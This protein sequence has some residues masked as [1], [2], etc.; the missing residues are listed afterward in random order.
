MKHFYLL[1][2]FS[3]VFLN[4]N[5]QFDFYEDFE[6]APGEPFGPW[7]YDCPS[8]CPIIADGSAQSGT[9]SAVV[10]FNSIN[11]ITLDFMEHVGG[12][13]V[14]LMFYMYIPAGKEAYFYFDQNLPTTSAS[15]LIFGHFYFN[16]DGSSPGTAIIKDNYTPAGSEFT[17]SYPEDQWFVVNLNANIHY[18]T[19]DTWGLNVNGNQVVPFNTPLRDIDNNVIENFGGMTFFPISAQTEYFID[20][21]NF[22]DVILEIETEGLTEFT[23]YPN[24]VQTSLNIKSQLPVIN[25]RIYALDGTII[26]ESSI[27]EKLDVSSLA[28]GIYFVE[29]ETSVGK[30]LQKFIKN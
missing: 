5:A 14:D 2:I 28:A 13:D 3:I 27:Q 22:V 1:L 4:A 7:W 12:L 9:K 29:V 11:G 21:I 26:V 8:M 23:I 24:P 17:F 16:Q 18:S 19:D 30:S 10:D 15:E 25:S 20:T 6:Y